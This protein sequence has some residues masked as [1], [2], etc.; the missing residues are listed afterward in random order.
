MR[1]PNTVEAPV[2][3]AAKEAVTDGDALDNVVVEPETSSTTSASVET[4]I[5]PLDT[6]F[7]SGHGELSSAE[8]SPVRKS[9]KARKSQSLDV[10]HDDGLSILRSTYR[11]A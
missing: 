8:S 5:H 7:A 9:T 3:A 4:T 6:Q 1:M 2:L 11:P 10:H